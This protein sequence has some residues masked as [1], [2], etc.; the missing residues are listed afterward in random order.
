MAERETFY[1]NKGG[2]L[3][4][5]VDSSYAVTY[6][7]RRKRFYVLIF[8]TF[9]RLNVFDFANVFYFKNVVKLDS[10]R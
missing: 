5:I 10:M 4:T 1:G 3:S 2:S 7:I 8:V 9:L 6:D